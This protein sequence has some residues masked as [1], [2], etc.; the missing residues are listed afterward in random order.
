MTNA[1]ILLL[2]WYLGATIETQ[3]NWHSGPG[4]SV[5]LVTWGND[6]DT[7]SNIVYS[8]PNQISLKPHGIDTNNWKLYTVDTNA[9]IGGH[10][11][12]M[13]S[14]VDLD[15]DYD[16]VAV[17]S[18]FVVWYEQQDSF[19][20]I[21]HIIDTTLTIGSHGTIWPYDLDRD[22]DSDIVVSGDEGLF[23]FDNN[24]TVFTQ[25]KITSGG[26]YFARAADIE[27]DGD[28]DIVAQKGSNISTNK[29]EG[30]VYVFKNGGSM[31]FTSTKL[32]KADTTWRTN[33]ADFNNDGFLDIQTSAYNA[34]NVRVYLNDG[35]GNFNLVYRYN[36]VKLDG[37]WPSDINA[38]G[39]MDIGVSAQSGDFFWL[40]NDGTGNNFT[41]HPVTSG[42]S[43]YG[44]GGMAVDIDMSDKVDIIGGYH[45]IGWFEQVSGGGFME[46]FLGNA[47][48]CHWVYGCNL[49]NG[50]CGEVSDI[51]MDILYTDKGKFAFWKNL[52]AK[53]YEDHAWIESSILDVSKA[54][55]WLRFG[56]HDCVPEGYTMMYR[57]RCGLTIPDIEASG[58]SAPMK[59]S[60]DSLISLPQTRYFQYR[61]EVDDSLGNAGGV[62]IVDTI[63][64]EYEEHPAGIKEAEQKKALSCSYNIARKEIAYTLTKE[65]NVSF[66]IY[67]ITGRVVSVINAENKKAGNHT[68]EFNF[69]TGIYLVKL[70]CNSGTVTTKCVVMK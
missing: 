16:L 31:N 28:I 17:F 68:L 61:I 38:D 57:V 12:I 46:H 2:L 42:I 40:E 10:N 65:S 51:A 23:W 39:F 59:Y 47:E 52:M 34:K 43:K 15:G 18:D 53:G 27:N 58:W 70:V 54:V 1:I 63:W 5:S 13:P 11:V 8:L 62:A 33:L 22:G 29:W 44:D 69:P 3:T 9:L 14:D 4:E 26:W 21:R 45:A 56:W 60:G 67:D 37:S 50:P 7:C 25:H 19:N 20:F 48:D 36:S 64:V 24:S 55:L 66:R 30:T 35:T 32:A 6:F 41:Y 49:G